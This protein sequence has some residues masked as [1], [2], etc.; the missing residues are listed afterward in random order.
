M[1]A[2]TDAEYSVRIHAKRILADGC[3]EQAAL[4]LHAGAIVRLLSHPV[5]DVCYAAM[6]TLSYLDQRTQILHAGAIV[7]W[8]AD[9]DWM[10][11]KAAVEATGNLNQEALNPH[12]YAIVGMLADDIWVVRNSAVKAL[13]NIGHAALTSTASAIVGL[14]SHHV[15]HVRCA[16]LEALGNLGDTALASYTGTIA[17]MLTDPVWD[18]RC[19]TVDLLALA[20]SAVANTI[21]DTNGE[22]RDAAREAL[23]CLK[24]MRARLHWATARAYV[25]MRLVRPY[26]LCWNEYVGE[27]LCA[28]GGKWRERDRAAFEDEFS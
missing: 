27:R 9:P 21:T 16:A 12:A 10:V 23:R 17:G 24:R 28:P 13:D 3:I 20:C 18:A 19:T 5:P 2:L 26:A 15:W 8:F 25:H 1:N 4:T 11:R 6:V 22:V 14:L 7:A